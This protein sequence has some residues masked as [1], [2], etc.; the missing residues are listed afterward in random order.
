MTG[1]QLGEMSNFEISVKILDFERRMKEQESD[2][3]SIK[4]IVYETSSAVKQIEKSVNKMVENSDKMRGYFLSALV[5][6]GVGIAF[7]ALKALWGG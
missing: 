6:G 1:A 3:K 4:P 2:M 5:A 7:F